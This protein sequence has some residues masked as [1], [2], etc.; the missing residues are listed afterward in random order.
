MAALAGVIFMLK[1]VPSGGAQIRG[2]YG[3]PF[4]AVLCSMV[5][6]YEEASLRRDVFEL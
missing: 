2:L 4:Q 6:V 5:G 3:P 1:G